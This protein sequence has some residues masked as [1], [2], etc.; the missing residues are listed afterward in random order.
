MVMAIAVTC[1]CGTDI[2][3][4]ETRCKVCGI[5]QQTAMTVGLQRATISQH[6]KSASRHLEKV[7]ESLREMREL[8]REIRW[9]CRVAY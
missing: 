1:T 6:L 5:S 7:I 8:I 3:D 4:C 9:I 2:L